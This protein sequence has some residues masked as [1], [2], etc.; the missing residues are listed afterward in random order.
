MDHIE[1]AP[2]KI[3]TM[4]RDEEIRKEADRRTEKGNE[5]PLGF[6]A[7]AWWADTHPQS[8][9]VSIKDRLPEP[10]ETVLVYGLF[11]D[12]SSTAIVDS[13]TVELN[14]RFSNVEQKRMARIARGL[15]GKGLFDKYGFPNHGN[16]KYEV[17]YWMPI[18]DFPK[19]D[20][21]E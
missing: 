19:E 5:D 4:T 10:H 11:A 9:W 1:T 18:P 14:Q 2:L 16:P 6:E 15:C 8:P 13:P 3:T 21:D 12:A 20:N 17:R 7:G